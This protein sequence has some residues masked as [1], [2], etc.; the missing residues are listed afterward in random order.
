MCYKGEHCGGLPIEDF[1]RA[2]GAEG[3]PIHRGYTCTM[4]EQPVFKKLIAKRPEYFRVTATPIADQATKEFIYI[5]QEI[6][7][8]T[9]VDM[10]DVAAAIRKV[11]THFSRN[12]SRPSTLPQPV[13]SAQ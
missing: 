10:E 8:G 11:G 9:K 2:C 3:S 12:A 1:L 7:L 13:T 6:F 5:P 4:S